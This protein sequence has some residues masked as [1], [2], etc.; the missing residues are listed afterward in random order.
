MRGGSNAFDVAL[1][2]DAGGGVRWVARVDARLHDRGIGAPLQHFAADSALYD[3]VCS[4]WCVAH[5]VSC[6]LVAIGAALGCTVRALAC[7]VRTAAGRTGA[8]QRAPPAAAC[9]WVVHT[10]RIMA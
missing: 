1:H 7:A 5:C 6:R 9:P 10:R 4:C 8:P 2:R 3:V